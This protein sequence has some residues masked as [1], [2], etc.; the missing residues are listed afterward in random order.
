MSSV[1]DI[2]SPGEGEGAPPSQR[3]APEIE[4]PKTVNKPVVKKAPTVKKVANSN[5]TANGTSNGTKRTPTKRLA[6]AAR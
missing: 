4:P 2:E 1:T 3:E 5:G 6:S